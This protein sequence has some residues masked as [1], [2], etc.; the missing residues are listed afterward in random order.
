[1]SVRRAAD[2]RASERVRVLGKPGGPAGGGNSRF[3]KFDG[4]LT[5][6]QHLTTSVS[7]ADVG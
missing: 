1:M 4:P 6:N 3:F 2:K 5:A 7:Q